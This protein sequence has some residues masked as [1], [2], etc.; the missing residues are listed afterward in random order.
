MTT[1]RAMDHLVLKTFK[2]TFSQRK[3]NT[4][5]SW[6]NM[7]VPSVF[8]QRGHL[9]PCDFSSKDHPQST[10]SKKASIPARTDPLNTQGTERGTS[11]NK[12]SHVHVGTNNHAQ[13]STQLKGQDPS[14]NN[15]FPH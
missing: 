11:I 9:P 10:P 8:Q 12:A 5:K 13:R 3:M 1:Q 4:H 15:V 2:V 7:T 6:A 14:N